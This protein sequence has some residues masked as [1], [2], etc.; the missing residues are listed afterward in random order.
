MNIL[1]ISRRFYPDVI[2]GGQISALFI[3]K[4]VKK[5][6]HEV[7]VITYTDGKHKEESIDGIRIIRTPIPKL[8]FFPRL[9]NMEYMYWQMGRIADRFIPRIKPDIIHCL[10][11]ES[12]PAFALFSRYRKKIPFVATLNGVMLTDFIGDGTD[13]KGNVAFTFSNRELLRMIRKRWGNHRSYLRFIAPLILL[14]ARFHMGLLKRAGRRAARLLPVSNAIK[15]SLSANGFPKRQLTVIHN[16]IDVQQKVKTDLK[17]R[18]NIDKDKKIILYMGRLDRLKG[19]GLVIEAMRKIDNAVFLIVGKGADE[20]E[21]KEMAKKMDV[22]N[23]VKFVGY[24]DHKEVP[25]YYSIADIVVLPETFFE[26][27]SR[28]LLEACSFGVPCIVSDRGGNREIIEDGKNGVVLKNLNKKDFVLA[29]RHILDAPSLIQTMEE[30]GKQKINERF[31]DK[32]IG[33]QLLKQYRQSLG[34][35]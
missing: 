20:Q 13:S 30:Y 5:Q 17:E 26:P 14:Y 25:E 32:A 34:N 11:T 1:F 4:A 28:M 2:G 9:S 15:D 8:R 10:N 19:I 16:P 33:K 3:A 31:S 29:V 24:V 21:L 35:R 22:Q 23:R 18:L 7:T 12:I 6:G 27:L